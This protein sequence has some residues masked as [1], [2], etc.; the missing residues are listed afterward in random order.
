[1]RLS[2][3]NVFDTRENNFEILGMKVVKV[4]IA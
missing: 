2:D 3:E 4:M 1:M